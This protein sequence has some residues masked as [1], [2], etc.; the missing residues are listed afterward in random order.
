MPLFE[1]ATALL[2]RQLEEIE[3]GNREKAIVVGKLTD[4]QLAE[5]SEERTADWN[6]TLTALTFL[7]V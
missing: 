4:A 1:Y 2:R 6:P 7:M 3:K 5:I